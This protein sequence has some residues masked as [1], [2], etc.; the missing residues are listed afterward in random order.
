M[1]ASDNNIP[2]SQTIEISHNRFY[3]VKAI[4]LATFFGGIL[5]GGYMMAQNFKAVNDGR[6]ARITWI[7]VIMLIVFAIV[8]T[9]L[10][11]FDKIPAIAYSAFYTIFTGSMARKYQSAFI[12]GHI[13]AGSRYYTT[14][15]VMMVTLISLILL[16]SLLLSV[17]YYLDTFSVGNH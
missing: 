16:V 1:T 10:P 14:I 3:S 9:I 15:R 5:A 13:N 12:E 11:A 2:V 8:S 7:C 4:T 17:F 6:K